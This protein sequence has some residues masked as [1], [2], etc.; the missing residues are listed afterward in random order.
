MC[1]LS[2]IPNFILGRTDDEIKSLAVVH[3]KKPKI[4]A[5]MFGKKKVNV[6]PNTTQTNAY[7]S[8]VNS[9][10]ASSMLI[11]SV[12]V[13]F[14]DIL[15]TKREKVQ[16]T[17]PKVSVA[18]ML[19]RYK[20][21]KTS[22]QPSKQLADGPSEKND[23]SRVAMPVKKKTA[24]QFG[25]KRTANLS[26]SKN[27][28]VPGISNAN[29]NNSRLCL[30]GTKL[31]Q[32]KEKDMTKVNVS[33]KI[34][35]NMKSCNA[36]SNNNKPCGPSLNATQREHSEE[37][38]E[39][40]VKAILEDI[41]ESVGDKQSCGDA[42]KPKQAVKQKVAFKF[43]KKRS[44]ISSQSISSKKDTS[45]KNR[46]CDLSSGGTM[47]IQPQRT[48]EQ[49]TGA[50]LESILDSVV[51]KV[52]SCHFLI[53]IDSLQ[54]YS[55]TIFIDFKDRLVLHTCSMQKGVVASII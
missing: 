37:R 43:G 42:G 10:K 52:R 4:R 51:D 54:T 5:F 28:N 47:M 49:L 35:H 15:E 7:E 18:S 31:K 34:D 19:H 20:S 55:H 25:S 29:S 30:D 50:I 41:L 22:L 16:E 14:D 8:T 12:P 39:Q 44:T 46:L 6:P 21:V 27:G 1:Y 23:K 36:T 40:L 53:S 24:F 48:A 13:N 26:R 38:L 32:A 33:S 11:Q 2:F 45:I 17:V 9:G 3:P